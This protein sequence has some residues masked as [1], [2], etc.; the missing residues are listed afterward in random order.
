MLL[1][2]AMLFCHHRNLFLGFFFSALVAQDNRKELF[3]IYHFVKKSKMKNRKDLSS[4]Y[5]ASL[6][7][8]MNFQAQQNTGILQWLVILEAGLVGLMSLSAQ[9]SRIWDHLCS[10]AV[11][12]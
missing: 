4:R 10:F 6:F 2:M 7:G 3:V 8:Q 1:H 12:A 9:I 11:R 5:W